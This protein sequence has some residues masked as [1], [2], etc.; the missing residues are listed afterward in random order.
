MRGPGASAIL[1]VLIGVVVDKLAAVASI[2]L[3]LSILATTSASSQVAA[4]VAG[5]ATAAPRTAAPTA[6]EETTRAACDLAES[7]A[8]P[9]FK[10]SLRRSSGLFDHEAFPEPVP[11]CRLV[12]TGSFE[13]TPPGEDA[14]SRLQR[15][16]GE[17]GWR[18]MPAHSADGKD[19]TAFAFRKAGVACFVRGTWDG[20]SD[21]EPSVPRER[22]YA[23][24]VLCT[25]PG[26]AE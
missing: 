2:G 17:R 11:G 18:E 14:A 6:A 5:A 21:G 23:V 10:S 7:L 22:T 8:G 1:S 13:D 26:P 4:L 15:G 3:L 12:I 19:G 20:G 9:G 16:F 25:R 24:S